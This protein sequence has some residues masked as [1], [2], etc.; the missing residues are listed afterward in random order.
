MNQCYTLSGR[1]GKVVASH[2]AVTSSIP[3]EAALI[4]TMHE[5]LIG[6][7]A[8]E[9]VVCHQSIGSIVSDAIVRRWLWSTA[10]RSSPLDCFSRLL[11]VVDNWPHILC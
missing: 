7:T 6:C 9:G 5:A 11:Q 2:D 4:Y 1:T 10:I 8:H 3:A